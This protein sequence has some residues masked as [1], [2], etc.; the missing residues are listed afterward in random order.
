MR[1]TETSIVASRSRD[2][3]DDGTPA[4]PPTAVASGRATRNV[5]LDD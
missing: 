5:V 4:C 2:A 1:N 3:G